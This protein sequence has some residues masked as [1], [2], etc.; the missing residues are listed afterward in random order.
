MGYPLFSA[1]NEVKENHTTMRPHTLAAALLLL[2]GC[3][4][5]Q[6][7]AP[8]TKSTKPAANSFTGF[9]RN[10][11]PGDEHLAELHQ[12]FAFTGFWLNNP[13]G[14]RSNTWQGKREILRNAGFGFLVLANGRMDRE[15]KAYQK[16][17]TTPE[18]LGRQDATEAI[19]A[20]RREHF[21]DHTI[22]FLDQEE[23]GRLLP[24]QS[25]YLLA[26]TETFAKS[27]YRPGAYLS[28]QPVPDGDDGHGHPLTVTTAQDIQA[29]VKLTHLTPITLFVYQDACPP[30]NG[31]TVTPPK[32]SESGTPGAA[33]WQYAQS[34]RRPDAT[35]SCAKTYAADNMCY[36]TPTSKI[37]V[38]LSVAA[39]PDPSNGR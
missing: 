23:G 27:T 14:E 29:Q 7:P 34:P 33:V 17:G 3:T 10:I 39:T 21:P 18:A 32:L 13:P 11:Y 8:M 9:D 19:A 38:D 1:S 36:A 25:Q 30:S 12:R 22:L 28:G 31:C 6:S 20:A 4:H 16:K 26:W 15:I 5:A 37:F 2:T 24:E 35:K